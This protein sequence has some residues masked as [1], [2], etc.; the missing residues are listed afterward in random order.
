M[1]DRDSGFLSLAK[2]ESATL[3]LLVLVSLAGWIF[4]AWAAL[5]MANP[6][7]MLMMP[8]TSAWSAANVIAVF[9]MWSL[10][11][12]AMMLPSAAPM[13]LLV[14]N[15]N[16]KKGTK[17]HTLSFTGAYLVIWFFFSTAAVFVQW[18]LQ[19]NGLMSAKMVS[20]SALLSGILLITVGVLQFSPLKSACLKHCR[21]PI[22]FLMTDWRKGTKG[23]WVMGFRHGAYCLGCCYALM[24]L[25][26]VGGVMNLAWVAA[27]TLAVAV[28]KIFP[29]GEKLP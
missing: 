4:L 26:F 8:M 14:A 6:L 2:T 10:M 5:D 15:L 11:M 25:L 19:H 3:N 13:I 7:A 22:G 9:I 23:A 28:E 24:L 1:T 29:Q 12:M 17:L 21:S 18:M 16:R 20:S 27:L